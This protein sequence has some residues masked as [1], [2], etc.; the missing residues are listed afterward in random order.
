MS[1]SRPEPEAVTR[2]TGTSPDGCFS[3]ATVWATRSISASLVGA[4]FEPEDELASYPVPAAEGRLWKYSGPVN[5]WPIK[6]DPITVPLRTIRLPD[7]WRGNRTR[8]IPVITR[9]Y[10]NPR[11]SPVTIV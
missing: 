1:G 4:R 6:L 11:S 2:S 10:P 3:D 7:V 5:A 8:A 9:G